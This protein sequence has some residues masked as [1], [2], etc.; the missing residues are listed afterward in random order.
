[1]SRGLMD[2][3]VEADVQLEQDDFVWA[4]Y[5]YW[6]NR[7]K[8]L[9][10]IL[11]TIAVIAIAMFIFELIIIPR[12]ATRSGLGLLILPV[13]FIL[14]QPACVYLGSKRHF[15]SNRPLQALN[16]YSFSEDGIKF[17]GAEQSGETTWGNVRQVYETEQSLLFFLSDRTYYLVPKRCFR[18]ADDVHRLKELVRLQLTSHAKLRN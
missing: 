1:M 9:R 8:V 3:P 5:W 6:W 13:L 10:I 2:S 16:R 7:R 18:S 12:E 11:I 14:F 4:N 17:K 15:V